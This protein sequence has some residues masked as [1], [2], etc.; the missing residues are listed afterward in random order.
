MRFGSYLASR[1]SEEWLG[2]ISAACTG[3]VSPLISTLDSSGVPR[4]EN[5]EKQ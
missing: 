1:L 4:F 3:L 2:F 5:S